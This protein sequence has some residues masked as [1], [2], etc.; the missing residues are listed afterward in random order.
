ML[1]SQTS[2]KN[3]PK[4]AKLAKT[5]SQLSRLMK[6]LKVSK[7]C[8]LSILR[9]G[10]NYSLAHIG[11]MQSLQNQFVK[12]VDADGA[13]TIAPY[14]K[15]TTCINSLRHLQNYCICK[16]KTKQPIAAV[17]IFLKMKV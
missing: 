1:Y 5:Y 14:V 17:R 13:H 16:Y 6:E 12:A 2:Q 9:T 10:K 11:N 3:Q 7:K 8:S 4:V 15:I